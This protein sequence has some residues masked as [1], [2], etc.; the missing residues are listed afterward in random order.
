MSKDL[1]EVITK[2]ENWLS[3]VSIPLRLDLHNVAD[4]LNIDDQLPVE[5]CIISFVGRYSEMRKHA[6]NEII[7]RVD[8]NQAEFG[9]LIF[10]RGR[11]KNQNNFHAVGSK[12]WVNLHINRVP[13]VKNVFIDDSFDHYNSVKSKKIRLLTSY[14]FKYKNVQSPRTKLLNMINDI[15]N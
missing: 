3:G 11:N 4:F 7:A 14:I 9:V 5:T 12:A 1:I 10:E 2:S 8:N 6:R 13:N 15:Y